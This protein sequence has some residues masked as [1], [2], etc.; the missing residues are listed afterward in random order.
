MKKQL[1]II[2]AGSHASVVIDIAKSLNYKI[3]F[4]IDINSKVI[5]EEKKFGIPVKS[6]SYISKIKKK[7]SIFLAIGNNH[8]RDKFY[9][10]YKKN[11]KFVNLIAKTSKISKYSKIGKANYIGPNVIINSGTIINNNCILNTS[12]VIEH[13]TIIEN[14]VHICPSVTIGGNC[15]IGER[16]FIGLGSNIIDKIRIGKNVDLGAGSLVNK[17]L[18]SNSLYYGVPAKLKR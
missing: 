1:F 13:D 7:S 11:F 4:I 2:G 10:K 5:L 9:E 16:S 3:N 15:K 8:I 14:S 12:S 17:Q 6:K 18:K